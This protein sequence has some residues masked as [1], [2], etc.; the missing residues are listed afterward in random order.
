MKEEQRNF[1][2]ELLKSA[3]IMVNALPLIF[4]VVLLMG[5]MKIFIST[6]WVMNVFKGDIIRDTKTIKLPLLPILIYY[7]GLEFVV[8]WFLWLIIGSFLLGKSL[9]FIMKWRIK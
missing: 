1:K 4:G 6:L 5:L 9:G 7:F 3:K 2:R 8:V